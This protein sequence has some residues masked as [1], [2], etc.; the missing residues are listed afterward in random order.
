MSTP[1]EPSTS[2]WSLTCELLDRF[3]AGP[4][5]TAPNARASDRYD[6]WTAVGHIAHAI[7]PDRA[8]PEPAASG[9]AAAPG[10]RHVLTAGDAFPVLETPWTIFKPYISR[11][12]SLT[13]PA[14]DELP[15]LRRFRPTGEQL[16]KV[17]HV[18]VHN[19]EPFLRVVLAPLGTIATGHPN[20]GWDELTWPAGTSL[21]PVR[22]SDPD[23]QTALLGAI[24]GDA[25]ASGCRLLVLPELSATEDA[26]DAMQEQLDRLFDDHGEAALVVAGSRHETIDSVRR[27]RARVLLAGAPVDICH[28]KLTKVRVGGGIEDLGDPAPPLRLYQDG[29]FRLAVAICK[30]MLDNNVVE[31]FA[32]LGVTILLVP[33][34]SDKT[35]GFPATAAQLARVSQTL[36][37]FANGPLLRSDGQEAPADSIVVRAAQRHPES[38]WPAGSDPLPDGPV[39]VEHEL[40]DGSCVAKSLTGH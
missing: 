33:A 12:A 1:P 18:E 30:D 34:M 11:P 27:N 32:A 17:A 5:A 26:L 25:F 23:R 20:L 21:W 16:A 29:P 35:E 40:A 6:A 37:A 15:H 9:I 14:R 3:V 24:A 13:Q 31:L 28:D 2:W 22:P 4:A 10:G 36:S 19:V 38:S 39:W 7:L 8:A